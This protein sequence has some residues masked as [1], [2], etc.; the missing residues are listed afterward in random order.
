MESTLI[1]QLN[2]ASDVSE[3]NHL[4]GFINDICVQLNL[5][6]DYFGNVLISVSEAVNNAILHGNKSDISKQVVIHVFQ[7]NERF[8]FTIKDSGRGFDFTNLPDP[9][10]PDNI[11]MENGRGVFLMKNLADEVEFLEGGSLVK[12]LFLR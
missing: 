12:V 11:L 10:S 1:G 5:E 6:E 2:L 8:W 3:I 7:D 4:E 9:T